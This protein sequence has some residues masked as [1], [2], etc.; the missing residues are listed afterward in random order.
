MSA[1]QTPPLEFFAVFIFHLHRICLMFSFISTHYY[2]SIIIYYYINIMLIMVR[3]YYAYFSA[4]T[5]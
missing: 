3:T 1:F 4:Y 2:A 5:I